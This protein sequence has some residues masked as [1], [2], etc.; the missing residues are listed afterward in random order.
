MSNERTDVACAASGKAGGFL[1]L[2]WCGDS[3][4]DQLA[5]RSFAL[6]AELAE[7]IDDEWSYR[8]ADAYSGRV[9]RDRDPQRHTPAE[10][11]WLSDGIAV[12]H[13]IGTP[14]TTA[15]VHPRKFTAAMQWASAG[16]APVWLRIEQDAGHGGADVV[17]QQVD[18]WADTFAFVMAQLGM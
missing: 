15:T 14:E 11:D 7:E 5:R 10:L 8:R 16:Q 1:A 4:L 6:H 9:L 12:T 18:E 17:S 2:D 13:R 3:P